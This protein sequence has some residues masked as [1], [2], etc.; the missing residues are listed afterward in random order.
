[1]LYILEIQ[2]TVFEYFE[3]IYCVHFQICNSF[4]QNINNIANDVG[5]TLLIC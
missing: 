2:A 4:Y 3:L 5:K 1:M